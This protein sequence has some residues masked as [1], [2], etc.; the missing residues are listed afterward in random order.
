ML[1]VD[2][3]VGDGALAGDLLECV[4]D[5]GAVVD[6]VELDLWEVV[7]LARRTREARLSGNTHDV[8]L[9]AHLAHQGL[10]RLAVLSRCQPRPVFAMSVRSLTGQYDLEK[11][12]TGLSW[13]ICSALVFAAMMVFGEGARVPKKRDRKDMVAVLA[14]DAAGG[15]ASVL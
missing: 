6:L 10:G 11:M 2:E 9:R 4:L 5:G 1:V 7:W 13:M 8:R 15:C 12:A 14:L 3:D